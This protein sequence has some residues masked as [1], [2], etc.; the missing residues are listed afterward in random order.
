M[1]TK[2]KTTPKL[3]PTLS[4]AWRTPAIPRAATRK[5][6]SRTTARMMTTTPTTTTM[7]MTTTPTTRW[8]RSMTPTTPTRR[9]RRRSTRR[10]T[11]SRSRRT[12][13]ARAARHATRTRLW[14]SPRSGRWTSMRWSSCAC[15]PCRPWRR[16][17]SHGALAALATTAALRGWCCS[18]ANASQTPGAGRACRT[19]A[20][21]ASPTSWP[22]PSMRATRTTAPW[23]TTGRP[24]PP[25]PAPCRTSTRRSAAGWSWWPK[26]PAA[27]RGARALRSCAASSAAPPTSA[28]MA[29]ASP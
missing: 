22:A 28:A 9:R 8:P 6:T 12:R 16:K 27:P 29:A 19:R 13:P 26:R 14:N 10:T 25:L 1:T 4:R 5:T 24:S 20:T 11:T 18:S 2:T 21:R 7:M 17:S 23:Q 15:S 3:T